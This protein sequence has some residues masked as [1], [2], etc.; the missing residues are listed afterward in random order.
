MFEFI[1]THRNHCKHNGY[2]WFHDRRSAFLHMG[3]FSHK[4][5]GLPVSHRHKVRHKVT[6]AILA[7]LGPERPFLVFWRGGGRVT[8]SPYLQASR[9]PGPKHV[10]IHCENCCKGKHLLQNLVK[11][12]HKYR[13]GEMCSKVWVPLRLSKSLQKPTVNMF[14]VVLF[15]LVLFR[16][17]S[18]NPCKN[19]C[20]TVF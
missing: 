19:Q 13:F 2:E 4:S 8:M 17:R 3:A 7:N 6:R 11:R 9:G 12:M 10:L 14:V 16:T 1:W 5:F 18:W 20:E 15:A